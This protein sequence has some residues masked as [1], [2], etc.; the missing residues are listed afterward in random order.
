L[1]DLIDAPLSEIVMQAKIKAVPLDAL[2]E[3]AGTGS[4][5]GRLIDSP[6]DDK[7]KVV[8][9]KYLWTL[10]GTD[11]EIARQGSL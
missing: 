3:R 11:A 2:R 8:R 6:L 4:D 5:I 7:S 9:Q 10:G 1:R